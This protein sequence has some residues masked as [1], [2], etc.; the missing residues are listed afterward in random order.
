MNTATTAPQNIKSFKVKIFKNSDYP[1]C[2][3]LYSKTDGKEVFSFRYL[4]AVF[5]Y[6][7]CREHNENYDEISNGEAI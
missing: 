2:L 7:K 1:Y 4:E 6:I 5:D 3:T